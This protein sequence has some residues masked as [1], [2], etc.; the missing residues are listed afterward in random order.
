MQQEKIQDNN[1][2]SMV[3]ELMAENEQPQT[4]D[5]TTGDQPLKQAEVSL[6]ET[7]PDLQEDIET[8]DVAGIIKTPKPDPNQK[9]K[10]P[11]DAIDTSSIDETNLQFIDKM[12]D[13]VGPD[14]EEALSPISVGSDG[15]LTF[16]GLDLE[17]QQGIQDNFKLLEKG[18]LP[19]LTEGLNKLLR[20]EENM[21]FD[22]AGFS[23]L[24]DLYVTKTPKRTLLELEEMASR[25]GRDD[26]F[27]A[28]RD[29]QRGKAGGLDEQTWIRAAW[30][31]SLM[32]VYVSHLGRKV[33]RGTATQLEET[34]FETSLAQNMVLR[35]TLYKDLSAGA[36]KMRYT[37]ADSPLMKN[38]TVDKT[39]R[40]EEIMSYFQKGDINIRTLAFM[41]E[42]LKPSQRQHFQKNFYQEI[43]KKL[44]DTGKRALHNFRH[45]TTE[46]YINAKLSSPLTHIAN[47]AGNTIWNTYRIAEYA[48]AAGFNKVTGNT[49]V[50]AIQFSEVMEMVMGFGDAVSLGSR[51]AAASFKSGKPVFDPKFDKVDLQRTHTIDR[52]KLGKYK[53]TPMG[54]IVEGFGFASR[55]PTNLLTAEDEFF[56]GVMY[57][58]ELRR[59]ARRKYNAARK[60]GLTHDE[61]SHI[62]ENT[63][64]DPD[65]ATK[66]TAKKLAREG[67][68]TG[69]IPNDFLK[70]A[71]KFFNVPEV[72]AFV[73]FYKTVM[74]IF[75]EASA[76]IPGFHLLN[77]NTRGKLLAGGPEGQLVRTRMAMGTGLLTA[78]GSMSYGSRGEGDDWFLTGM[79]PQ[80]K[81]AKKAFLDAGFRPY[82]IVS[83][84]EDGSYK[85]Y[86]YKRFDPFGS[87]MGLAAD[88]TYLATRPDFDTSS[89]LGIEL[90][91]AGL[92]AS[93]AMVESTPILDGATIIGKLADFKGGDFEA[94]ARA[95]GQEVSSTLTD[96]FAGTYM[97]PYSALQNSTDQVT[98]EYKKDYKL[99]IGEDGEVTSWEDLVD[100]ENMSPLVQEIL[101]GYHKTMNKIRDHSIFFN[102]QEV[103]HALNMWGEPIKGPEY[104]YYSFTRAYKAEYKDIDRAVLKYGLYFPKP[105]RR[106]DTVR[107]SDS[108][109]YKL[110]KDMNSYP[111]DIEGIGTNITLTQA[112]TRLVTDDSW[113]ANAEGD[114][115]QRE[116]AHQDM[117]NILAIYREEA[118]RIYKRDKLGA[119]DTE[120]RINQLK[121]Y[122]G[123][124]AVTFVP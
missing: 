117:K 74:N 51:N 75:L 69:E 28:I 88:I 61:A 114:A 12:N 66:E 60:E 43:V 40:M 67:T 42:D 107:L 112:V 23:D 35:N 49:D 45:I 64:M 8:F 118:V 39:R 101:R 46:L 5:I 68:F 54:D 37:Q 95:N 1:I 25:I 4:V 65:M 53:D 30:E 119:F 10:I 89:D 82:S 55:L 20:N 115:E 19:V 105:D 90:V 48:T 3:N 76:R 77:K 100:Y 106:I 87:M 9:P 79:A 16:K 52:T 26:L 15:T 57:T 17:T 11:D 71:N 29:V 7:P 33:I 70:S 84:Q 38:L 99:N 56:K 73:P 62:M 85:S 63:L 44:Y 98:S 22:M 124:Q 92:N 116:E 32:D 58:M 104:K 50:D 2:D 110:I 97:N 31:T 27:K 94:W 6:D 41:L 108:E 86:E 121:K 96:F 13:N 91:M 81:D 120:K 111:L 83:K 34:N 24:V 123:D 59:L 21:L 78:W 93:M 103:P 109:Y 122:E 72:K 47:V 18:E 113:I 80:N 102:D 14:L 36:V